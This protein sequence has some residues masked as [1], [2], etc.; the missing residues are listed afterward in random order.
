MPRPAT[1]LLV[2]TMHDNAHYV[3]STNPAKQERERE[4]GE[5]GIGRRPLGHHLELHAV[6]HGIVARLHEQP[7]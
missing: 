6:D 5:F 1:W 4:I 2:S 3:V 7:P